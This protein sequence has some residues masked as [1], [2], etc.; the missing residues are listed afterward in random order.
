MY[1]DFTLSLNHNY[2]PRYPLVTL[3]TTNF[4]SGF[5][6]VMGLEVVF[7]RTFDSSMRQFLAES[8]KLMQISFSEVQL[9]FMVYLFQ[10]LGSSFLG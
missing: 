3:F 1:P 2:Y 10:L 8:E 4:I 5:S 6:Y 9:F 7:S